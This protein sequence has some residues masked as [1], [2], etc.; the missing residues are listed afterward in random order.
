MSPGKNLSL[1][2]LDYENG[3]LQIS[4]QHEEVLVVRSDGRVERIDTVDLGFPI[5]MIDNIDAFVAQTQ[6][7]LNSD[8]IVVLYTDGITEAEGDSRQLY[9][10]DRLIQMIH[11]HRAGSASDIRHSV[12]ED[13]RLHIGTHIIQDDIT[14]VVLKKR[15][16]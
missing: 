13:V 14:L 10:L 15:A 5:G 16:N 12:I 4:G 8:D 7:P 6:I 11:H 3:R 9:G 2:L 1:V